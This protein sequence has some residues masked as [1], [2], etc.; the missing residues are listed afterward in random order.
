MDCIV[1]KLVCETYLLGYQFCIFL[2]HKVSPAIS[3]QP[4]KSGNWVVKVP[5]QGMIVS[6]GLNK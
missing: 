6:F 3:F 1:D 4:A 5:A 2:L